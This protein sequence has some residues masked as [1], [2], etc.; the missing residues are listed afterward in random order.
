MPSINLSRVY[1]DSS[2]GGNILPD[3]YDNRDEKKSDDKIHGIIFL[4]WP[5]M[6]GRSTK[7][8][9]NEKYDNITKIPNKMM[10]KKIDIDRDGNQNSGH[11]L[12]IGL[13]AEVE[14]SPDTSDIAPDG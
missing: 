5:K 6:D 14:N 12:W 3:P 9:Q 13:I 8:G 7:C 10:S 2:I 4:H 11:F 1:P